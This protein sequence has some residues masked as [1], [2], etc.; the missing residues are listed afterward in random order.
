MRGRKPGTYLREEHHITGGGNSIRIWPGGRNI[1]RPVWLEGLLHTSYPP[2]SRWAHQFLLHLWAWASACCFLP[3]NPRW[4]P[5]AWI[6]CPPPTPSCCPPGAS[7][8]SLPLHALLA[9]MG[10][11]CSG[12]VKVLALESGYLDGSQL[13]HS[14]LWEARVNCSW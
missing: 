11:V 12:V 14:L 9:P 8:C 2:A 6:T 7:V 5:P 10:G 4:W 13:C 3:S 1:E